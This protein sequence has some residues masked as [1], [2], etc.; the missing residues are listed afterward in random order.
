MELMELESFADLP[1]Y[2]SEDDCYVA[3]EY[4]L[5]DLTDE[6]D[7]SELL[8]QEDCSKDVT[9]YASVE[10]IQE[11]HPD[12]FAGYLMDMEEADFEEDEEE[13]KEEEVYE[14]V[15]EEKDEEEDST[16][17]TVENIALTAAIIILVVIVVSVIVKAKKDK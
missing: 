6:I 8:S 5:F 11:E 1:E 16:L 3:S 12:S 13:E 4:L 17:F 7:D 10:Q 14:E 15:R 2:I 9:E